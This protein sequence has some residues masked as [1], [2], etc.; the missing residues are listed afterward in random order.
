MAPNTHLKPAYAYIGQPEEIK[1]QAAQ[2]IKTV[3]CP[4]HGCDMCITCKQ[5][6]DR[7]HHALRWF[8]PENTYTVAHIEPIF[9]TITFALE[10][11]E[12]FFFVLERADALSITCANSLLKSLE[13]PPSGYHF[14]LL[15]SAKDSLLPTISS[16]CVFYYFEQ[17]QQLKQ[18]PL[19]SYFTHFTSSKAQEFIKELERSKV[20]ERDVSALLDAMCEKLLIALQEAVKQEN[21]EQFQLLSSQRE[22]LEKAR[23][24]LPMPG[25]SKLFFKNLFLQLLVLK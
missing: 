19:V 18:H 3:L 23:E 20:A 4:A 6:D 13:E 16:R 17:K 24:Q 21:Y 22:V 14:I 7:Q 10:P 5:I 1:H 8:V 15:S 25:S 12:H 2:F 9:D 11:G